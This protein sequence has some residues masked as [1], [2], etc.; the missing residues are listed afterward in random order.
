[1]SYRLNGHGHTMGWHLIWW[2]FSLRP[3]GL[4]GSLNCSRFSMVVIAGYKLEVRLLPLLID[5]WHTVNLATLRNC[6]VR[7][8]YHFLFW[9]F[10]LKGSLGV[11]FEQVG[12]HCGLLMSNWSSSS[13]SRK[14]SYMPVFAKLLLWF[15]LFFFLTCS[16]PNFRKRWN[17][18]ITP[19]T[20][21]KLLVF[22]N[23][24]SHC[25]S[26][27]KTSHCQH[28]TPCYSMHMRYNNTSFIL[29]QS[30]SSTIQTITSSI[31]AD[32]HT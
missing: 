6:Y 7:Y 22:Q 3:I 9:F 15:F 16:L 21:F 23:P 11:S 25:F 19:C 13:E 18:Y 30:V 17:I 32:S 8:F 2:K 20:G 10:L 29:T 24:P 4:L 31:Q 14:R 1:M 26:R 12:V 27:T 5:H 28:I